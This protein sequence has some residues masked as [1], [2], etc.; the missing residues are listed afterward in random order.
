MCVKE[1]NQRIFVHIHAS[2]IYLTY[3]LSSTTPSISIYIIYSKH[4]P[5]TLS[6]NQYRISHKKHHLNQHI[7]LSIKSYRPYQSF[8]L[9]GSLIRF[10]FFNTAWLLLPSF[11]LLAPLVAMAIKLLLLLLPPLSQYFSI[12]KSVALR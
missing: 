10:L 6:F 8:L 9:L 1:Y 5:H 11:P 7:A 12:T 2:F 4:N 3:I